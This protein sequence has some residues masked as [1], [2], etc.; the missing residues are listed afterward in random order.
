MVLLYIL[1]CKLFKS[2]FYVLK[3]I[4]IIIFII[5][6]SSSSGSSRI[7]IIAYSLGTLG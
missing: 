5:S 7:D 4:F 2:A 1:T 3:V 6:S